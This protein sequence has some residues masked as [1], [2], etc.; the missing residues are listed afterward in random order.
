LSVTDFLLRE[1]AIVADDVTDIRNDKK[2]LDLYRIDI[3]QIREDLGDA[4]VGASR[5][6]SSSQ[7]VRI[8]QPLSEDCFV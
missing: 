1:D 3:G 7:N 5:R 4:A 8:N 6:R 2:L